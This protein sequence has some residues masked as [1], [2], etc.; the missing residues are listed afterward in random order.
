MAIYK[1]GERFRYHRILSKKGK[2]RTVVALLSLTA[3]VDMFTVLV[4]FLLQNFNTPNVVLY[5]PKDLELP[6]AESTKDL[7]PAFVV[8]ISKSEIYLDKDVIATADEVKAQEEWLIPSL[9]ERLVAGLQISKENFERNLQNRIR[10]VV[11]TARG[12][13]EA[14]D[15]LNWNKVTIQSDK[16]IDFLTVKKVMY[17]ITEAG[18]GEINFAVVK[19][20]PKEFTPEVP[21]AQE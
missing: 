20:F 7:K 13:Q 4:V 21:A 11:Q 14:E 2:G 9:H 10:E 3:M 15:E 6:K 5:V 18:A 1:P 17:T 16:T 12:E 8:T 19:E